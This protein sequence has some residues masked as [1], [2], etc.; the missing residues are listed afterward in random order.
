MD[1]LNGLS[2]YGAHPKAFDPEQVKPVLSNLSIIIK[3]Y[4]KYKDSQTISK[5]RTGEEQAI[6]KI[7]IGEEQ[8]VGKIKT[9]EEKGYSKSLFVPKENIQKPR[10]SLLLLLSGI[11]V[12]V[13]IIAYPK[14][15]RQ[16]IN[17]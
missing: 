13:A 5:V 4:L 14:I 11:L 10:M 2:N 16:E 12:V 6:G 1:H 8:T 3:W 15:F 9:E 7:R 17:G